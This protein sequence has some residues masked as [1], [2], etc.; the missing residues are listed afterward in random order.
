M[1]YVLCAQRF[2]L[3][4]GRQRAG[5]LPGVARLGAFALLVPAIR[6]IFPRACQRAGYGKLPAGVE[7]LEALVDHGCR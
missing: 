4:A 1:T 6:P 2:R 3:R 7:R 5:G